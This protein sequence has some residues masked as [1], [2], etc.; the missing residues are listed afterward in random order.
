MNL[1]E[2][3]SVQSR[4]RQIDSLQQLRDSFYEE[5]GRF[6]RQLREEREHVAANADDPFD[7]S[8]VQ[9]LSDEIKTAEQTVEAVY[10]RRIGK[11]VK[12]ASL[13]AAGMAADVEGLT[14]EERKAFNSLV[15]T[16]E[17][18]R[19]HVL[20]EVLA[21]ERSEGDVRNTSPESTRAT[22][23]PDTPLQ[24]HNQPSTKDVEQTD[25][26]ERSNPRT[27]SNSPSHTNADPNSL[28]E[29]TPTRTDPEDDSAE[30]A[31]ESPQSAGDGP[32]VSAADVMGDGGETVTQSDQAIPPDVPP[33]DSQAVPVHERTSAGPERE[34][35]PDQTTSTSTS[36]SAS[37]STGVDAETADSDAGNDATASSSID[38]TTVRITRDVGEILCVDNRAYNLSENDVVTLPK[39]NV[40]PLLEH[41]AAV[42]LD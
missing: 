21:S 23:S 17:D 12:Q 13:E 38:R 29:D 31:S 18:N 41:D 19:T 6:I 37:M 34:N 42:R 16:I 30:P 2:L 3:Q 4:E 33:E 15:S 27:A 1:D 10:E 11:L 24:E 9:R 25:Q 26:N 32:T 7:S 20:D 14:K 22:G 39:T 8:D 36:T 35:T 40:G 28:E 5:A